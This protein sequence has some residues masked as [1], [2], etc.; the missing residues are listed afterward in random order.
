M[1][2]AISQW[3][4]KAAAPEQSDFQKPNLAALPVRV[5]IVL[6]QLEMTLGE[7]NNLRPGSIVELDREKSES[8]Q[9][10]VNGKIAGTGELVEIEGRLGVRI[11]N[12]NTQ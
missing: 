10:A 1:K 4:A 5:H 12:W 3:K 11:S 6:S 2:G 8:V 9:L 7:L